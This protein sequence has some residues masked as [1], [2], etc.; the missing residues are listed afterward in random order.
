[1]RGLLKI[2]LNIYQTQRM[3][4]ATT[5]DKRAS[6]HFPLYGSPRAATA[7]EQLH[8]CGV[9]Q[10]IGIGLCGAISSELEI[11]DVVAPTACV[12]GDAVSLHYAPI[13]LPAT[14][15]FNLLSNSFNS[16]SDKFTVHNG[17]Q[18]STDALYRETHEQIQ[19]WESMGV[20]SIDMECST[21]FS[22]SQALG[23]RSCW[24]GVV[25]DIIRDKKHI[26]SVGGF[27]VLKIGSELF[28]ELINCNYAKK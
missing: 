14:A 23:I 16:I 11:G 27:D 28:G 6:I 13:E 8:F 1:M 7:I 21:L 12:R 4:V 5:I 9:K 10:I 20:L 26:G 24:Y 19:L 3:P 18:Y 17:I 2:T 15:D 25:S 22:V